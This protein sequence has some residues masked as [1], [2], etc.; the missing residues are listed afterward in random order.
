V[1]V[2]TTFLGPLEP[3]GAAAVLA[4]RIVLALL[5][6]VA[7]L[8]K[9]H[10]PAP[11]A[12]AAVRFR[13]MRKETALFAVGLGAV[14]VLT[15]VALL[16]PPLA[17]AGCAMAGLLSLSFIAVSVPALLRGDRFVC[18]CLFGQAHLSWVTPLRAS[19]MAAGAVVALVVHLTGA[20]AV[21]AGTVVDALGL[22]VL[23]IGVPTALGTYLTVQTALRMRRRA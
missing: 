21:E 20:P 11:A 23:A 15:A 17:V 19:A 2:L 3:L 1:S 13:V 10:R 16:A 9:L 6:A 14:E 12:R 5:F 7:G 4:V 22:A 18:G 8:G